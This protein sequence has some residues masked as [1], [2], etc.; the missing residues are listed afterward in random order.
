M[1]Y[2]GIDWICSCLMYM[3]YHHIVKS[4]LLHCCPKIGLDS[5]WLLVKQPTQKLPVQHDCP[6]VRTTFA[7]HW[8]R[9]VNGKNMSLCVIPI[10]NRPVLWATSDNLPAIWDVPSY[11]SNMARG[12]TRMCIAYT[13]GSSSTRWWWILANLVPL[14]TLSAGLLGSYL[15][16]FYC[17][18]VVQA[19]M[20]QGECMC[21]I[22]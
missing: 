4:L 1:N 17:L 21:R 5:S 3:Q 22:V 9:A 8:R 14:H 18:A 13:L 6:R 2:F 11:C 12:M 19:V 20:D 16:V 7:C 15:N 10:W